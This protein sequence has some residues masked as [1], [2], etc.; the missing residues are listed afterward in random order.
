MAF[1]SL[2]DILNLGTNGT[3]DQRLYVGHKQITRDGGTNWTQTLGTWMDM[4]KAEGRTPGGS[5]PTSAAA[6]TSATLGA[7]EFENATSGFTKYL[8]G[9]GSVGIPDESSLFVLYDR[10]LHIGGLDGTVTTAQTVGG[11]ITRNTGGEGNEIWVVFYTAVGA[12]AQTITAS[13]TNQDGTSGRTTKAVP[14]NVRGYNF[15]FVTYSLPLQDGDTG[16]RAVASVTLSGSTGTAGNF[17][18]V[19]ARPLAIAAGTFPEDVRGGYYNTIDGVLSPVALEDDSC[20]AVAQ[21]TANATEDDL[22]FWIYTLE[23]EN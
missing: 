23:K 13:Y 7:V 19:I 5:V 6:P 10:L 4:W 17:G 11:S 18:I 8:L 22:T 3:N 14:F 9:F 12:T 15:D 20:L 21:V 1:T 2:S 16:V